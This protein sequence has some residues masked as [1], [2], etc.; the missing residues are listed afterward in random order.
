MRACVRACTRARTHAHT[1]TRTHAH[2]HA[3][4]RQDSC[5]SIVLNTT[6]VP[7]QPVGSVVQ[8]DCRQSLPQLQLLLDHHF[9]ELDDKGKHGARHQE[10]GRNLWLER[11]SMAAVTGRADSNLNIERIAVSLSLSLSVYI[12]K[13]LVSLS[14]S[15]AA[16]T[17]RTKSYRTNSSNE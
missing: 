13:A 12:S 8:A 16:A 15:M 1:H 7:G 3:H 17:G 5:A 4:T 6:L 2:T 10:Q 11:I 14:I 9:G